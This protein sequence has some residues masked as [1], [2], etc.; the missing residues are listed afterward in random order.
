MNEW[1]SSNHNRLHF[2]TKIQNNEKHMNV[3]KKNV[4]NINRGQLTVKDK[5][6]KI[7][8]ANVNH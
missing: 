8:N 1:A 3:K 4:N 6:K 7:T 2:E 5:T